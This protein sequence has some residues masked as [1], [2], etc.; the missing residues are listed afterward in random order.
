MKN[1]ASFALL[2]VAGALAATAAISDNLAAYYDFEEVVSGNGSAIANRV[3]GGASAT[4][5]GTSPTSGFAGNAAFNSTGTDGA[6]N[7]S[8]R[9]ALIVGKAANFSHTG[10]DAIRVPVNTTALWGATPAAGAGFSISAWYFAAIDPNQAATQRYFV[11]EDGTSTTLFDVSFGSQNAAANAT[12]LA[13]WAYNNG[14]TGTSVQANSSVGAW[15]H[16][17]HT[18]TYDG[19]STLLSVYRDGVSTPATLSVTGF[20][21]F[22]ELNFGNARDGQSRGWDGM[23]DEVAV[24]SRALAPSEVQG[25]YS[26]GLQGEAVTAMKFNVALSSSPE[27]GGTV[28]GSG[29]YSAGQQVTISAT[30]KPGYVFTSWGGIFSAQPASFSYTVSADV[31]ATA[32]FGEDTA[33]SDGDGLTNYEEIVIYQTLPN[34][35]DTDGDEIPDGD[36][37]DITGTNPK[38]SDALLVSFVRNNLSTSQAGAIA[39]SP[40]QIE[41]NPTTGAISL[42][43][44]LSGSPNQST[45]Q[46]I[47]LSSATIAPAGD[48]W[49]VTFPAPSNSVNSYILK[50]AQP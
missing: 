13:M 33:D 12:S 9:S 45:W 16:V 39:L 15:H 29:L 38:T 5:F 10:T 3:S 50:A 19:T 41:R 6:G 2:S 1:L 47:D 26:L 11:F 8:N 37:V 7:T 30:P 40:L 18:F 49:N 25:V 14:T 36:E 21:T 27:T 20:P 44:S 23:I 24:W 31:T 34:N 28:S 32:S 4:I 46:D 43:L 22:T 48:G 17:V 42:K 35:P